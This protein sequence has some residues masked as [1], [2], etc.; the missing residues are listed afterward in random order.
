MS[1]IA[2]WIE[3][4][5][6]HRMDRLQRKLKKLRAKD[7]DAEETIDDIQET[8][9][10]LDAENIIA[11]DKVTK[12][13]EDLND[14]NWNFFRWGDTTALAPGVIVY[15]LGTRGPTKEK[16]YITYKPEPRVITSIHDNGV[17]GG[18]MFFTYTHEIVRPQSITKG[19]NE[20]QVVS[21][22][23]VIYSPLTKAHAERLCKLLNLQSKR[24]YEKHL[25]KMKNS[26]ENHK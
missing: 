17:N 13:S 19:E 12:L 8:D 14:Y 5:R 3:K 4:V 24:L 9:P 22:E 11:W 18:T 6:L 2:S 25:I 7:N 1:F 20:F 26:A 16:P 15:V 10:S 21:T 23:E